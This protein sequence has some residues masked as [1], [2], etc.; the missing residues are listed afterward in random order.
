MFN[1]PRCNQEYPS[2]NSLSKHTRTAYKISGEL[3]YR[4]YY[5]IKQVPIC[6]CGCGISTKWRIDRGYGEYVNGHNA[7]TDNPMSGKPHSETTKQNISQKRKEK[8]A[9]GEYEIWQHKEG[10]KY[11]NAK[12]LIG[13]K[14]RKENNPNRASK[15]SKALTGKIRTEEH[16][17]KL[18]AAIKKAWE[19]EELRER[20]RQHMFDR[21]TDKG[22]QI[23]SKLEDRFAEMLEQLT[24]KYTRQYAVKEIT[25][26]YDFHLPEH[27]ILIEVHGDFWHNNPAITKFSVPKY[28]AQISN[29][30]SDK[31]KKEWCEKNNIQLL[32]FWE[33]DINER[34]FWVIQQLLSHINP[35]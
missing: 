11:E 13:E 29:V 27:K 19:N 12:K 17:Q 34:P 14:S 9:N 15:I 10:V 30:T 20:Q 2:Y 6:K 26:L 32:V 35:S 31:I 7:R 25:S 3:L 4:E 24:I 33:T 1:C 18:T 28:A 5:G 23:T 21:I 22:W 8:F 16:Q